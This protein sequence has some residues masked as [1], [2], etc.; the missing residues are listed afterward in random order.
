MMTTFFA[1][2]VF[3][4]AGLADVRSLD[5]TWKFLRDDREKVL[6]SAAV[7]DDSAWQD[8]TVPHDW[9]IAGPFDPNMG[10]WQGKLP[11]RGAGWYRRSFELTADEAKTF[12]ARQRTAYL[13]F[14]GVMA[15]PEV[16]VNG[17]KVGG[18]DYGYMSFTLDVTKLLKAGRNTLAVK[19]STK[20]HESRWYPGAG[21]YRSVRLVS[22][23]KNH[24]LPGTLAI[25]TQVK[26][27]KLTDGRPSAESATVNVAYE[28]SE[29]GKKTTSF[30]VKRN[31][32]DR[33]RRRYP[34][35]HFPVAATVRLP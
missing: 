25:T 8:V 35:D 4:A 14:D 6:A 22:R 3:V 16:F 26:D 20:T 5:G 21:L 13:E 31:C 9:A 11:W 17:T 18:W 19:A 2:I 24:V 30:E 29:E 32:G 33:P 28:S 27:L 12:A 10:G 23:P 15:R 34:S 7:F 1:S